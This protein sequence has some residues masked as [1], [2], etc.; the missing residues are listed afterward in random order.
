MVKTAVIK[1]NPWHHY[2]FG[3][4]GL[5]IGSAYLDHMRVHPGSLDDVTI[6]AYPDGTNQG[7]LQVVTNQTFEDQTV[8]LDGHI[9]DH[10]TFINACLLYE[11]GPYQLQHV[12]FI[13]KWRTCSTTPALKNYLSLM[14]AM[15]LTN[16]YVKETNKSLIQQ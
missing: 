5:D 6:S 1:C 16:P 9:Y 4:D 2:F 12:T 8:P 15:H 10:C 7:T 3:T 14:F 11:G 13:N